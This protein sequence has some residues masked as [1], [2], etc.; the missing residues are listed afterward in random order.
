MA[1]TIESLRRKG[2]KVWIEGGALRYRARKGTV[3]SSDIANILRAEK[4]ISSFL[5]N[6]DLAKRFEPGLLARPHRTR[7]QLAFSQLAHWKLRE[8]RPI[9]QVAS[10]TRLRG[11][12]EVACLKAAVSEVVHRHEALRTRIVL[13]DGALYRKSSRVMDVVWN[14]SM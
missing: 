1:D 11:P 9:R 8:C 5:S 7:A 6:A 3:T 4:E 14:C 13:L 2:V 12:L 10:V